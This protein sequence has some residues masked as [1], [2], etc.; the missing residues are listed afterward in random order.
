VTGAFVRV[1]VGTCRKQSQQSDSDEVAERRLGPMNLSRTVKPRGIDEEDD[2]RDHDFAEP[3]CN[4]EQRCENDAPETQFWKAHCGCEVEHIPRDPEDEGTEQERC[5]EC[6]QRNGEP[7]RNE[8]A[9]P[10]DSQYDAEDG[11]HKPSL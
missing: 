5:G 10:E 4:K 8:R 7:A 3:A 2:A 11:T 9:E 6:K 1:R